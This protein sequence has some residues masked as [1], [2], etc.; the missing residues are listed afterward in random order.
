NTR[1]RTKTESATNSTSNSIHSEHDVEEKRPQ[2]LPERNASRHISFSPMTSGGRVW[3]VK[4]YRDDREKRD[5]P[6]QMPGFTPTTA[7]AHE[8]SQTFPYK[9][10]TLTNIYPL[11][12]PPLSPDYPSQTTS[13]TNTV[14]S[15]PQTPTNAN[16]FLPSSHSRTHTPS[17]SLSSQ[18]ISTPYQSVSFPPLTPIANSSES[19]HPPS[20]C[21]PPSSEL[22]KS[23]IDD[24]SEWSASTSAALSW[25]SGND[26]DDNGNSKGENKREK[27]GKTERA[28]KRWG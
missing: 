14:Y 18:S 12:T 28:R 22:S 1:A 11:P 15:S 7:S 21:M 23:Q 19:Y 26:N 27:A 13:T 4:D 24:V 6:G 3:D 20:L 9:P 8:S 2:P 25:L 16:Q 5:F 10:L 17:D